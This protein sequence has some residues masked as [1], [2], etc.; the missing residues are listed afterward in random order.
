MKGEQALAK[1]KEQRAELLQVITEAIET[2]GLSWYKQWKT[3]P[4]LSVA[5]GERYRGMNRFWLQ[6]LAV[7]KEY[8]DPRWVSF[9]TAKKLGWKIPEG[10][11]ADTYVE[12]WDQRVGKK[13]DAAGNLILDDDGNEIK[14]T[15]YK[16]VAMHAVWNVSRLEGPGEYVPEY[17]ITDGD[18]S[19]A[20]KLS[21]Y[22]ES[23]PKYLESITITQAA[24]SPGS[25]KIQMPDRKLFEDAEAFC[26][27][28][29]HESIHSTGHK[30][31]LNRDLFNFFGSPKYAFEELV[32]EL[33]SVFLMQDFGLEYK[34]NT[35]MLENHAAYLQHWLNSLKEKSGEDYLNQA[36][37]AATAAAEFIE[38]R[39][40]N[41]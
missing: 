35:F 6:H 32:A 33:G 18:F 34:P 8:S 31:R 13:K 4:P 7:A 9:G 40:N 14:F 23:G 38:G 21:K 3:C 26:S 15:Y 28:L 36:V 19:V 41:D 20:D 37:K 24:Y 27:T 10:T 2:D 22:F 1:S 5:T 16:L 17:V 11:K 39:I 29:A 12:A 25:D 30:T